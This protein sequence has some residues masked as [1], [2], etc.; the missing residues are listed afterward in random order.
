MNTTKRREIFT[1]FRAANPRPTTELE[2]QTPFQLLIAV[3]LSAQATDKSVNLATR[4][5]FLVADTPEKIL[6]LG[7]TGLSP[8]I[9]RI[10]LFR[11]KTR[12]IL[13]TCQLLIEQYNGEVP[14]T[15]TELEKLPGV[16]RKTA[17]V[18][19][20]TAFGEP[21]IA[22]DTH[23]FR[24]ANR[25]GIAPGKNVLEVERKLLKVVPDEFRHDAHHWLILHGRYIC[26][27]RKPL[28]HQCLIVDLCEFKE[29]NLE[30]T[31]SSL[32]MKQLT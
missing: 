26:K 5:L 17:S 30:G 2:Y 6:Q 27:A 1:R 8:F 24:V 16:G 14:R 15:R 4:K 7:E 10:G 29:K 3:I 20:N 32:D 9:Q 31:A 11:T 21:T 12:N 25:I 19:L 28:C 23:I 22:V 13:A 18:I